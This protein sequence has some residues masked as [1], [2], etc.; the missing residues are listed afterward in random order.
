MEYERLKEKKKKMYLGQFK[1][2]NYAKRK[3]IRLE[4]NFKRYTK[5]ENLLN[6]QLQTL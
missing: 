1:L 4:K 3:G 6:I 2:E 5:F